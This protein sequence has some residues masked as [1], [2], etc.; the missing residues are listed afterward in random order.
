MLRLPGEVV[1]RWREW[2]DP[3]TVARH[4]A[5]V[6]ARAERALAAWE[7][8][9]PRLLEG[10]HVALTA[11]AES[12]DGPCVLKVKPRDPAFGDEGG[13]LVA[14]APLTPRLLDR[15]DDGYTLLIELLEPGTALDRSGLDRLEQLDV[16]GRLARR[17]RAVAFEAPPLRDSA[18]A[19]EWLEALDGAERDRLAALLSDESVLVHTDLHP[20]NVLDDRGQWRVI[21][22]EPH[23]AAP[24]A[25][26]FALITATHEFLSAD[27]LHA[28]IGRYCEAAGLDPTRAAEWIRLRTL[29]EAGCTRDPTWRRD[30]VAIGAA[31]EP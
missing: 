11:A 17:L 6:E 24:E 3:E 29:A 27:E 7:L 12:A 21:D 26:T 4:R 5:D 18:M 14:C 10:G 13:C 15:R 19:A 20:A 25:E 2:Y 22:P 8:E 30:L 28:R 1:A 23:R 9:R 31:L 16:I